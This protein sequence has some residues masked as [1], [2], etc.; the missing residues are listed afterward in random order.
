MCLSTYYGSKHG[1]V[2]VSILFAHLYTQRSSVRACCIRVCPASI[3]RPIVS[4]NLIIFYLRISKF[5]HRAMSLG[6]QNTLANT[7]CNIWLQWV[8]VH[9]QIQTII[10]TATVID[11]YKLAPCTLSSD[12]TF[13]IYMYIKWC[14]YVVTRVQPRLMFMWDTKT[15]RTYLLVMFSSHNYCSYISRIKC[16][17]HFIALLTTLATSLDTVIEYG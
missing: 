11:L 1:Y 12:Y 6:F 2:C 8:S 5:K 3:H 15:K 14:N 4:L 17:V 16:V 7:L 10:C 13:M 9:W